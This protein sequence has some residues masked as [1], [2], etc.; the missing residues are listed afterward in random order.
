MNAVE[1]EP[2]ISCDKAVVNSYAEEILEC[3]DSILEIMN[4]KKA[5]IVLKENDA[6]KIK[7]VTKAEILYSK[8]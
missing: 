7:K 5:Y 4:I 2:Y 6:E 8:V 3:I 1:C